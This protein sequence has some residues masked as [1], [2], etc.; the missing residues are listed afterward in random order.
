VYPQTLGEDWK[1]SLELVTNPLV[2]YGRKKFNKIVASSNRGSNKTVAFVRRTHTAKN[3]ETASGLTTLA[4]SKRKSRC[5]KMGTDDRIS[6]AVRIPASQS[7]ACI[8]I[9]I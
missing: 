7:D 1:G 3:P 8:C 6:A 9:E 2:N 4:R 5:R